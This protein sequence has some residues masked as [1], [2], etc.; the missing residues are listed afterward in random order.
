[1]PRAHLVAMGMTMCKEADV[2]EV[3]TKMKNQQIFGR[4][5]ALDLPAGCKA[6]VCVVAYDYHGYGAD[7]QKHPR[8]SA[9][10]DAVR[11]AKMAMDCGAEVREYYDRKELY[12]TKSGGFPT[13]QAVLDEWRRIGGEMT[14]NEAFVFYFA[15]HGLSTPREIE[16]GNDEMMVFMEPDGTPAPLTDVEVSRVLAEAFPPT[17]HIL[18]ITDCFNGGTL[19]DLSRPQLAGRPIVHLAAVKDHRHLPAAPKGKEPMQEVSSAFTQELLETVEG[20]AQVPIVDDGAV[21][22][23]FS[24]AVVYNKLLESYSSRFE[25]PP[26]DSVTVDPAKKGMTF[27]KMPA[28]EAVGKAPE[29]GGNTGKAPDGKPGQVDLYFEQTSK[30]DPDTFRWP[31]MPPPGWLI[32]D[33]LEKKKPGQSLGMFACMG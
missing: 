8:L 20:L 32:T 4:G 25:R 28:E 5:G 21:P 2:K 18:F 3:P 13:K 33:P 29:V 23:D 31:L 17:A 15:G 22:D 10:R 16:D 30:F 24:E 6:H 9:V 27:D 26:Q 7:A 14:A 11:F 1:V 19:C 12:E